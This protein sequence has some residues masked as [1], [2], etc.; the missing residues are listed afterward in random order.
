MLCTIAT[1]VKL[2]QLAPYARS[3]SKMETT[4]DMYLEWFGQGAAAVTV[5]IPTLGPKKGSVATTQGR[6]REMK[7]HWTQLPHSSENAWKQHC[8]WCSVL[9]LNL[10]TNLQNKGKQKHSSL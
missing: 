6:P 8:S 7:T 1:P 5:V 9:F 4:R 2:I 10:W 3:V